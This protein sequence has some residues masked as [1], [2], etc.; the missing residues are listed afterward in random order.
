MQGIIADIQRASVHDGPGTRTTV[1]FK[2]CPLRCRWCHNPEC[3]SFEPQIMYY[4]DKCIG[5]GC[6]EDGCYNGARVVCGKEMT[7]SEV[8]SQILLDKPYYGD[9]GG[10]TFSGGEPM[11]QK[12]FLSELLKECRKNGIHTA[13]ETSMYIFD[14]DIFRELDL[15]MADMKLWDRD[16]HIEYTGVSNERIID[17]FRRLDRSG[18]PFIMRTP[19]IPGVTDVEAVSGF[20]KTMKN[21]IRHELLPYHPLGIPKAAALGITQERFDED[22]YIQ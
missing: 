20:A 3:I 9:D 1:F 8:M 16:K 19:V 17:N 12:Q 21:L 22:A 14:N 13:I 10:V 15:V 11:A 7:V 2:G 6:C 18:I 4:P 5:C